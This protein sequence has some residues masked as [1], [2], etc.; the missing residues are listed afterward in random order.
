M[1]R[2]TIFIKENMLFSL[3]KLPF[4]QKV[5]INHMSKKSRT[6]NC[7]YKVGVILKD[8]GHFATQLESS[9]M[10][11]LITED[12]RVVQ[13]ICDCLRELKDTGKIKSKNFRKL[14]EYSEIYKFQIPYKHEY[15]KQIQIIKSLSINV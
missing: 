1:I 11:T 14:C 15:L 3:L 2:T 9:I 13:Q 8:L 5:E 6:I 4:V 7:T 10:C 12:N